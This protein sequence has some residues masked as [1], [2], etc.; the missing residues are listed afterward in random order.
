MS[1]GNI[2][3]FKI[4]SL[5]SASILLPKGKDTDFQDPVS[6]RKYRSQRFDQVE[7]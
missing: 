5:D 6:A 3:L 7:P 4:V 2:L 1:K